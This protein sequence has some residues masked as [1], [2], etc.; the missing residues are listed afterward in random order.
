PRQF[1]NKGVRP[2]ATTGEVTGLPDADIGLFAIT[3]PNGTIAVGGMTIASELFLLRSLRSSS[4][5]TLTQAIGIL[6]G[7]T[8]LTLIIPTMGRSMAITICRQTKSS[9]TFRSNCTTRDII[10]GR[11]TG[12]SAP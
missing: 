12:F 5:S 9:Q 4:H 7:D 2:S 10:P 1:R 8:T 6:P 11:S 3:N